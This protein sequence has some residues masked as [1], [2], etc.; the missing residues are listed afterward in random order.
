M[1]I[2]KYTL[3]NDEDVAEMD[4]VFQSYRAVGAE[5]LRRLEIA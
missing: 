1:E 4:K 2:Y 5:V 3:D